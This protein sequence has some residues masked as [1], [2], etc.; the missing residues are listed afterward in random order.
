MLMS[1]C[2]SG[3]LQEYGW[4]GTCLIL[5][6]FHMNFCVFGMM[7]IPVD[8]PT[9][10]CASSDVT[11]SQLE[12][13]SMTSSPHGAC[14][15]HKQIAYSSLQD[16]ALVRKELLKCDSN[17]NELKWHSCLTL[18]EGHKIKDPT[19]RLTNSILAHVSRDL[20]TISCTSL[21]SAGRRAHVALQD[22]ESAED[23][24]SHQG[25]S[26]VDVDQ[27]PAARTSVTILLTLLKNTRYLLYCCN[28]VLVSAAVSTLYLY[29]PAYAR[30]QQF[31]DFHGSVLVS[32]IGG[33][34]VI[35]RLM[36]G[37]VSH[38]PKCDSTVYCSALLLVLALVLC[39]APVYGQYLVAQ[40]VIAFSAGMC[41]AHFVMMSPFIIEFAG[42]QALSAGFG[43]IIMLSGVGYFLGPPVSGT[44]HAKRYVSIWYLRE[45]VS[46]I[47]NRILDESSV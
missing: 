18:S 39:L 10:K 15:Q 20:L 9:Q 14:D 33:A 37:V 8:D 42:L 22:P 4:R 2:V 29:L 28:V 46:Q 41:N 11:S 16:L 17:Q 19:K 1:P 23:V 24:V 38:S 5:A 26:L 30:S 3:L 21:A 32:V 25:Q 35:C 27:S 31:S 45:N 13:K 7:Y 34:N 43:F 6:A 44:C 36:S 47:G 12:V 40:L